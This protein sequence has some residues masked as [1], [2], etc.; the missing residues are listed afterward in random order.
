[1]PGG[2]VQC[3]EGVVSKLGGLSVDYGGNPELPGHDCAVRGLTALKENQT[4]AAGKLGRERWAG[5]GEDSDGSFGNHFI[6]GF[7]QLYFAASDTA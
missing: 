7:D 4:G 6:W 5:V 3:K 1:M 2:T